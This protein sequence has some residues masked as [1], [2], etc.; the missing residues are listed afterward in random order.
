MGT[1]LYLAKVSM[2]I[3]AKH[4]KPNENGVRIAGLDEMLYRKMLWNHTP[5]TDFWRL[6][7]EYA[8]KLEKQGF[9]SMGD[10]ART[11]IKMKICY[12]NYLE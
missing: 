6:D 11:S 9:L 12:I 10:V 4:T 1:N 8:K 7:K 2:D 5:I 3:V